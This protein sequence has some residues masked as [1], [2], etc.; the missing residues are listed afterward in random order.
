MIDGERQ[1]HHGFQIL[2]RSP[3]HLIGFAKARA[4]A[5]AMDKDFSPSTKVSV[6]PNEYAVYN[7]SRRDVLPI[8]KEPGTKRSLFS[9]NGTVALRETL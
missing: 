6:S 9:I 4:I 7:I 3:T 1:E 8:G 5:I 2:V